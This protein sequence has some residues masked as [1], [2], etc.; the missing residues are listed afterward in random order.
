[1]S[2]PV[3]DTNIRM[4]AQAMVAN[5]KER[6]AWFRTNDVLW[7]WVSALSS[8]F[9]WEVASTPTVWAVVGATPL[10]YVLPKYGVQT[11]WLRSVFLI[12]GDKVSD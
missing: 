1:M 7:P 6:A 4:Y 3:T 5:I 11:M 9:A 10:Q 8:E 12:R 2:L